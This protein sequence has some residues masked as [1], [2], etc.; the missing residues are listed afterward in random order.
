L[1]TIYGSNLADKPSIANTAELPKSLGGAEVL[2]GDLP[3][4]IYYASPGQIYAVVPRAL[5]PNTRHQLLVRRRGVPA[6]PVNVPVSAV[7]PG[8]FAMNNQGTGQAAALVDGTAGMAA[9]G[10]PVARGGIVDLY[11]TGLGPVDYAPMDGA[12]A[13]LTHLARVT[14]PV[15]VTVGG[16]AAEVSFAG[17][18][19][20]TVGLY[21][22]NV[23]IPEDAPTGD[24]VEI[25]V[26]QKN[27]TSNPV[28]IAIR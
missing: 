1:I 14:I 7:Q 13:S 24:A 11:C 16:H 25:V 12:P 9:S 28:T 21:Q 26:S 6:V 23:K 2:L 22:I 10:S 3:L 5:A 19:P 27:A 15:T 20:G 18:S 17:L 4:P 8:L